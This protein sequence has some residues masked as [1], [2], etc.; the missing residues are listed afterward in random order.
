MD[1]PYNGQETKRIVS[2][3]DFNGN[4]LKLEWQWNHNPIDN[5]WSLKERKGY[6]RLK[7]ARQVENL[8]L[9]P[10]TISQ[11]MMGPQSIATVKIDFSKMKDGDRAG[12]AAFNGHSGVLTVERN[13]KD[14]VL[15][16]KNQTVNLRDGDKAVTSVD[17]EEIERVNIKNT[18]LWL[19]IDAD[20]TNHKDCASFS[21]SE[22]GK[23]FRKIGKDFRMRFD[24]RRF[25][26]G[27]RFAIFNYATKKTGG[28]IDVDNFDIIVNDEI[29]ENR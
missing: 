26:M 2:S 18:T 1:R 3:D 25:F 20:F 15:T 10:N 19:R 14:Y 4:K 29:S 7:T 21:F 27:T 5:A 22:D 9:A 13:G 23:N 17:S 11:R 12:F 28:Y 6:L 16:M 8:Y 24:Y